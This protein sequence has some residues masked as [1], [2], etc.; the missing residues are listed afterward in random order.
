MSSSKPIQNTNNSNNSDSLVPNASFPA[1][2]MKAVEEQQKQGAITAAQ[3]SKAAV[4]I[5]ALEHGYHAAIPLECHGAQC[6]M[7]LKCPLFQAGFTYMVNHPCPLEAHLMT[8]WIDS[9]VKELHVN[10]D[11]HTEMGLVLELAKI[12]IYNWRIANKLAYE[13]HIKAQ[14]VAM[15]DDGEPMYRDE[16]HVSAVWDD[17]LA[18]R[19]LKYMDA[20]LA[21]RKS[22]AGVGGGMSADPSSQMS[23]IRNLLARKKKSL[24]DIAENLAA[25]NAKD[26][27]PSKE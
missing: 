7:A 18:K 17:M 12:D 5:Q 22:V 6:P 19:R 15:S 26:I 20:L 9:I 4:G 23:Q 25:E 14:V 2:L 27:T 10:S 11:N 13:D 8:T 16:L 21:T 1:F 3:V 24:N